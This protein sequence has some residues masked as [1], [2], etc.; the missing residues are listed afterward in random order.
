MDRPLKRRSDV[1]FEIEKQSRVSMRVPAR[2]FADDSL[3]GQIRQ[4]AVWNQLVNVTTAG[5]YGAALGMPDMHEGYGFSVGGWR[6]PCAGR[7]HLARRHRLDIN[8]G[9]RRW[10]PTS[11]ARLSTARP[12]PSGTS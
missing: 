8:C 2:V 12:S 9:V 11:A 6:P 10:L 3:L 5:I 7:G 1:L 4:A